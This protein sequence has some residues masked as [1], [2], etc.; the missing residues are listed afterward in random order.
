MTEH[1]IVYSTVDG[2]EIVRGSGPEGTLALQKPG[3]GRSV[4]Q[5]PDEIFNLGVTASEMPVERLAPYVWERVKNERDDRIN[6]G[7]AT[8]FG[9]VDSDAVARLNIA[10][11]VQAAVIAKNAGDATYA[12]DWTMH[13]NSAVRLTAEAMIEVGLAVTRHISGCH[14]HAREI[15]DAIGAAATASE[16]LMIDLTTGW[17]S[18]EPETAALAEA[19]A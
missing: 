19:E 15:R 2:T 8:S 16:L 9:V 4:L 7:V 6:G 12:V 14:D 17:P 10:G 13:D 5:V 3:P 18:V 11:A 1:F